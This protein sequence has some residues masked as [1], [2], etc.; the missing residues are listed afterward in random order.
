[1]PLSQDKTDCKRF[2]AGAQMNSN[3]IDWPPLTNSLIC[4]SCSYFVCSIRRTII[5][6]DYLMIENPESFM[7]S[8]HQFW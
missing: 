4:N 2:L 3:A 8:L 1:M 7:D 5:Y 6:N